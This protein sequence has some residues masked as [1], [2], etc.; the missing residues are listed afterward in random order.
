[1]PQTTFRPTRTPVEPTAN[2]N[3]QKL[4]DIAQIQAN[5][6][7]NPDVPMVAQEGVKVQGNIPPQLKEAVQRRQAQPVQ[8]SLIP[9]TGTPNKGRLE[10]LI[11]NIQNV[12]EKITLPSK[13]RF[14]DGTNGPSD[15]VIHIR[16]MT[17]AEEQILATPRYTRK[18]QAIN[19]I[20]NKCM[21]ESYSSENFLTADRN[22]ML[23]Y[24][25]GIS[26]TTQYDATVAC[27]QCDRKFPANINLD[28]II[29]ETCPDNF[30]QSSL[31]GE[32]PTTKYKFTYRL[33]TG[34]DD[35]A[36]QDYRERKQKFD[37]SNQADDTLLYRSAM[38]V[39]EIE[40]LTDKHEILSLIRNLPINDVSYLRNLINKPPFGVEMSVDVTCDNCGNEFET[41]LPLEASFFFP[42]GRKKIQ[43][44]PA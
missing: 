38:L 2:E 25:R 9:Q 31:V 29:V 39:E 10:E 24:L 14:Y 34:L 21:Q 20:F 43:T 11:A 6:N 18:G 26:Y 22:Y 37:T 41:D 42:Q 12:Y 36:I 16:A 33:P 8:H 40:G 1:M 13:G 28:E 32:L 27:T 30:N 3:Q 19:M 7:A 5:A 15:G 4:N 17:G 23:I 35:Q 44:D